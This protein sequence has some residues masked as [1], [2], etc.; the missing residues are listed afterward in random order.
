MPPRRRRERRVFAPFADLL[1]AVEEQAITRFSSIEAHFIAAMGAFDTEIARPGGQWTSGDNQGK[2]KF[3][4]ELTAALLQNLTGQPIIQRGKRPGVLL[5]NVDVDLCFPLD[6]AP[7]VIAETKMLGTPQH[8]RNETSQHI[9]GRR[10]TADLPKRIREIALN[11]IDLKLAA[12]AGR[13]EPIGD[14]AT[15]IQ[16]QSPAFYALFG[17]RVADDYDH[18]QLVAQAQM[19]SNSYANGVGLVLYRPTDISTPVGRTTYARVRPP[20]GLALDDALARM[21]REIT[22]STNR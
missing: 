1:A 18:E 4:N 11:V 16:R 7:L 9:R 20:R 21:A 22:A 14:I 3:F 12:P 6:G 2:G 5:D 17:L 15:W 13:A 8:P 19:L 10:S